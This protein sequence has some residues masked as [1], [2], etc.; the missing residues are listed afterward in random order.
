VTRVFISSTYLD[1][2]ERRRLVQD[3]IL[4]LGMIPVGMERFT[5]SSDSVVN[6]S[7]R[8]ATTCDVYLC[9]VAHR[10]GYVDPA[11]PLISS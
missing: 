5:A 1:N 9:I 2:L 11:A 3:V 10:Y 6:V 7:T 4:L 8:E